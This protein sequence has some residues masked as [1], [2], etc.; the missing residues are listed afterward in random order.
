MVPDTTML[1]H[2]LRI[3]LAAELH[4][5]PFIELKTPEV[6]THIAV[7]DSSTVS[8]VATNLQ[9]QHNLL[10][11]LCHYFGVTPPLTEAK[12]FY[13]AFPA[14][15]L[16]WECHTEF[17]SYT[18]VAGV[19][20]SAYAEGENAFLAT[21]LQHLPQSWLNQLQSKVLAASHLILIPQPDDFVFSHDAATLGA[22]RMLAGSV[23]LERGTFLTDFAV[24]PDG[25]T[26][27][28]LR[29][30]AFIAQQAGRMVQ[31]ILEIDTYRMMAL[32]GLPLA[33]QSGPVL[34]QMETELT[35]L[36][37]SMP[38]LDQSQVQNTELEQQIL[39]QLTALASRMEKLAVDNS[40]RFAASR[41]Y[42]QLVKAR[43]AELRESRIDGLPT[44]AEFMERRLAPA[45]QTCES[46]VRRQEALAARIAQTND[47][48]R[49]R[50][51]IVQEQQNRQILQSMNARAAQQLRLQ[52][53]VEGLSVA[54]ITY[55]AVG[56]ISYVAKG[57]KAAGL[58]LNTDLLTGIALPVTGFLVWR[59]IQKLHQ[60]LH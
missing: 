36:V 12:Y 59:G 44:I 31:R 29:D 8:D 57:L 15:R 34:N 32:M 11:T 10:Q 56:L 18:F 4:S 9:R 50:V 60:K 14:F 45:M 47:L 41:A 49:T 28:V 5:R 27:F 26:R 23:V 24:H 25:F 33:Q 16:K 48:L 55:Y 58:P 6:L 30:R 42:F 51:G 3:P 53:A 40:Y 39:H 21:V 22:G 2:P 54:A 52:Q 37:A 46:I 38:A 1:S 43:I 17:A 20:E 13:H 19:G 35:S 7:C